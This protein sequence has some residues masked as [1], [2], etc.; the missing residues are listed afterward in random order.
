MTD[1]REI[2]F[3]SIAALNTADDLNATI[4]DLER[5]AGIIEAQLDFPA[6]GTDDDWERRAVAALG[7]TRAKIA[8]AARKLGHIEKR[9]DRKDATAQRELMALESLA[10]SERLQAKTESFK[11]RAND[12][13]RGSLLK[14]WRQLN[15]D[16][17]FAEAAREIL[18]SETFRRVCDAANARRDDRAVDIFKM[19]E[20]ITE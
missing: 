3:E 11:V 8:R 1:P 20:A 5:L 6:D 18:D 4:D 16:N 9:A 7:I 12:Q 14:A 19:A 17:C 10:A 15:V 13:F 2:T